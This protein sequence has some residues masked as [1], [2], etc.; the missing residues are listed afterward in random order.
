[1][2]NRRNAS[3]LSQSLEE[4][5]SVPPSR[6]II[7]FIALPAE[8]YAC[9]GMTYAG[10]IAEIGRKSNDADEAVKRSAS[11]GS[12]A[13]KRSSMRSLRNL[14][15]NFGGE[16]KEHDVTPP[17]SVKEVNSP[18]RIPSDLDHGTATISS[19]GNDGLTTPLPPMPTEKS[20]MDKL[21][22]KAQTLGKRRS[23]MDLIWGSKKT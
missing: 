23:L 9:D 10:A 11:R 8:N 12:K 6:G 4:A 15:L 3:L 16:K 17:A 21:A 2:T 7:K 18:L 19:L 1:M 14:K 13:R 5:L 20:N 22:E